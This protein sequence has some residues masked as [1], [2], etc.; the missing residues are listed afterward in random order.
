LV[1]PQA[2]ND[3]QVEEVTRGER[4]LSVKPLSPVKEQEERALLP[5]HPVHQMEKINLLG[6]PG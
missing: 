5:M 2:R 1:T 6:R 3:H 4:P